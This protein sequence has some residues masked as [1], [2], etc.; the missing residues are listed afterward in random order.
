MT[1]PQDAPT[2]I[3]IHAEGLKKT[4]RDPERGVVEAV[5]S[6]DM[7]CRRGE[8]FGLLGPNGA[9]KTTTLRMLSTI[10][11]PTAGTALGSTAST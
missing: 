2:E 9:G 3:A 8:I 11:A 1:Q 7:D 10:L 6:I 4:F 5:K